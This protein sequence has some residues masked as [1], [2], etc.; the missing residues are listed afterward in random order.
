MKTLILY[1]TK[2]GAAKEI[3]ERIGGKIDGAVICELNQKNIPPL[4][5]FDNVIIGS[6]V[7]AVAIRKEAKLFAANH[8]DELSKKTLG[9][10]LSNFADDEGYFDKNFPEKVVGAAKVKAC[11]GGIFDPSKANF[12][13]RFIIKIVMKETRYVA[14]LDD[15]KIDKFV[16]D[17]L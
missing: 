15:A 13:E 2:Y 8:A 4:A 16:A 14:R 9:L 5:D 11:L 3:A 12:I 7:Y 1:A 6:S 10:F 17:L